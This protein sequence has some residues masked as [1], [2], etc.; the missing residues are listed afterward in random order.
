M[1]FNRHRMARL[2][3]ADGAAAREWNLGYRAPPCFFNLRADHP[4]VRERSHLRRQI[5][6]HQVEL[7]SG[8]LS[9]MHCDFCGWQREYQPPTT[10]V[11]GLEAKHFRQER[12]IGLGVLAIHDDMSTKDHR[13]RA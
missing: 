11:D 4:P 7:S 13:Q 9:R 12:P 1:F 6:R 2:V 10:R 3:Q 5:I 8:R